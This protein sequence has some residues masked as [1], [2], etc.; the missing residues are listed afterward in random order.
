M[1]A[2]RGYRRVYRS[3]FGIQDLS[4]FSDPVCRLFLVEHRTIWNEAVIVEVRI[5]LLQKE[6]IRYII[7]AYAYIIYL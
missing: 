3:A 1:I 5:T 2:E 4:I 7:Y 6:R